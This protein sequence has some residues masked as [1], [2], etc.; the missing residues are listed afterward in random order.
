V[1]EGVNK[2][3][4]EAAGE[5][6]SR[7]RARLR[8]F[9]GSERGAAYVEFVIVAIPLFMLIFG[10]I[11]VGLIFWAAYELENATM[12]AARYIRTGQAQG[13]SLSTFQTNLCNNVVILTN[14]N[15]AVMIDVRSAGTL[16]G[17]HAPKP[18]NADGSLNTSFLFEQ[19]GPGVYV[20]VTAFYEWQ[21]INPLVSS[22]LANLGDG[23]TLLRASA[24]FKNEPFPPT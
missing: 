17:I 6:K 18:I 23:N 10:I 24:A 15:T 13:W 1:R 19:G 14:C 4:C 22:L 2:G 21:L 9:L 12:A 3:G 5:R 20:L 16:S 7:R 11:E 8:G